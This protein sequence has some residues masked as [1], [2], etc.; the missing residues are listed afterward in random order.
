MILL[1]GIS[2]Y[3]NRRSN[4]DEKHPALV[5]KQQTKVESTS[6]ISASYGSISIMLIVSLSAA[7]LAYTANSRSQ[8]HNPVLMAF[9]AFFWSEIYIVQAVVRY[10]LGDYSIIKPQ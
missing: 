10:G 4:S 9:V 5:H 3:A 2:S 1:T 6:N 7:T 8:K